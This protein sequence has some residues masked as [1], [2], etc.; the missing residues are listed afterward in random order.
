MQFF[1]K[2]F[3][4]GPGKA[5]PGFA[6]RKNVFKAHMWVER[7]YTQKEKLVCYHLCLKNIVFVIALLDHFDLIFILNFL[8]LHKA[9]APVPFNHES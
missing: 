9:S 6:N 1:R 7:W 4:G 3:R 8:S 2:R 5:E